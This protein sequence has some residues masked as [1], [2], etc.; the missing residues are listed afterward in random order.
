ML[1]PQQAAVFCRQRHHVVGD[2]FHQ[3]LLLWVA[4]VQRR[5][6]V[7]HARI[8]MAKHAVAQ[9][10][11]VEERAKLHNIIR[12]MFR[13]HAGIF[14]ERNRF[15]RAFGIPQQADRFFTHRVNSFNTREIV[16]QLPA[17]HTAFTLSDQFVQASTECLNL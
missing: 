16:T 7:Q 3:D 14:R 15:G 6:H 12:Q 17:N 13:R 8:H 5:A 2:L 10:V 1:A 4:H 9:A 11:A